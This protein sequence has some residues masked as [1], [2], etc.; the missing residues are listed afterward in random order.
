[1]IKNGMQKIFYFVSKPTCIKALN[2][3]KTLVLI[4][5]DSALSSLSKDM[6]R[7]CSIGRNI[8]ITSSMGPRSSLRLNLT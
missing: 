1:M 5:N 7:L 3:L 6:H 4:W 2:L 8:F